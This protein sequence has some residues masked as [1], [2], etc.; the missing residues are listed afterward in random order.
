MSIEEDTAITSL[1]G[2]LALKDKTQLVVDEKSRELQRELDSIGFRIFE[3]LSDKG[4]FAWNPPHQVEYKNLS[5]ITESKELM[6]SY[7]DLE[8]K[9]DELVDP[10]SVRTPISFATLPPHET[11]NRFPHGNLEIICFYV[12][13]RY[14][15]VDFEKIDFVFGGSTLEMLATCDA[16]DPYMVTIVPGTNS[17]LV[18]K[19]KDYTKNASDVGFQFERL[20]TGSS[21]EDLP[22]LAS[23]VEH[24]RVMNVGSYR[25]LFR[26]ETDA[27]LNG[28][29]IEIKAS[30]PRYWGSKVMFQMISSGSTELC[31]GKKD[32]GKVTSVSTQSL[33]QVAKTACKGRGALQTLEG[34]IVGGMDNMFAQL[35]EASPGEV[36]KITIQ[37]G[38]LKLLPT[39]GRSAD[40]LPPADIIKEL[41][42]ST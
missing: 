26:A 21:K 40:V 20:M 11:K 22:S 39:R 38:S 25:V 19:N 37:G 42:S 2:N 12:A 27:I 31:H 9:P 28:S 8:G 30:N 6:L 3:C 16:S 33:K 10:R 34:N 7:L 13:A 24:L 36:F 14:R 1:L 35:K 15:N 32:R 17:I 29:P 5:S 23:S 18:L 41:L 4:F